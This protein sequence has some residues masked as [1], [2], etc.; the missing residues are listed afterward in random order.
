M[1][2]PK[3]KTS[4]GVEYNSVLVLIDCF[5]KLVRYSL[6]RKT[7]NAIQLIKLLFRV[8]AQIGPLDNII[9]NRGSVFISKY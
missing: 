6:M 2:L 1:D 8:F 9:S 5:I 7:I 3:S 4:N